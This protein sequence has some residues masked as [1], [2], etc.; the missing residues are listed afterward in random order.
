MKQCET[1]V[2]KRRSQYKKSESDHSVYYAKTA[3]VRVHLYCV[4]GSTSATVLLR[5]TLIL[6][7][8][9]SLYNKPLS[10]HSKDRD[11]KKSHKSTQRRH[12]STYVTHVDF[13]RLY[14]KVYTIFLFDLIFIFWHNVARKVVLAH[15]HCRTISVLIDAID[16]STLYQSQAK[17]KQV[18]YHVAIDLHFTISDFRPTHTRARAGLNKSKLANENTLQYE[19]KRGNEIEAI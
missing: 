7:P 18:V 13:H 10:M 12:L 9:H 3:V 16:W 5:W 14:I 8:S 4:Y 11:R 6:F 19:V 15:L 2:S 17:Y 1:S